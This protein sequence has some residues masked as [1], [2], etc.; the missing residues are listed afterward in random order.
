MLDDATQRATQNGA[1]LSRP[2]SRSR[3]SSICRSG[4]TSATSTSSA[5][6]TPNL[7]VTAASRRSS[8]AAS[9]RGAPAS[10]SATTSR[11]RCPTTRGPTTSRSAPSGPTRRNMLRVAYNGSWFNNLDA[12]LVWD[13][14]LR[15]DRL[16]ERAGQRPHVAVAVQ[17]RA[18]D[19]RR[20]L[21]QVRAQDA[22]HRL[23]LVRR[24]EQ[25]RAAAAVHDQFGAADD[26]AAAHHHR[27]RRARLLDQPEPG[28]PIRRPTGGS[29]RA[30]ADY[31]YNNHTPA[32]TITQYVAYDSSRVDVRRPA[33]R[34]STRTT[35]PRST[36]T[37]PGPAE[38]GRADGRL[39]AQRQR[40]RRAHLRQSPAR[41]CSAC[42]PT[43]SAR[44]GPPSTR[45]TSTGAAPG[46][47]STR[48]C[49]S[50]I[51]EQPEMRHYDLADRTRNQFTGR[52][53]SSRRIAWTFSVSGGVGTDDYPDTVFGLQHVD[54]PHRLARAP[55]STMPNGLGAGG[56]LQLRALRGPP[57]LAIGE[58]VG[59]AV[60][61]SDCATGRP[62]S[63][64]TVNYFSIYAT[65]PRIGRE[66][67]GAVLLRLQL[68]GGQLPL[69]DRPAGSPIPPPNQLPNVYNK[70][71]QL[72]IDVRHRLSNRAGGDV[73]VSLRAVPRLRLRVRPS[74]VNG[75]V[76][77]SSLVLGYVYR[78]YTANSGHDRSQILLVDAT[79]GSIHACGGSMQMTFS[80]KRCLIHDHA[81]ACRGVRD[82][83]PA[84]GAGCQ[85]GAG[86]LHRA[87]VPDL[88]RHRRQRQQ[89]ESAGRRRRRSCRP[90]TSSSG[91][92]IRPR[93]RPRP[94]RPRSRRCRPSTAACR[95]L[96]STRSSPTCRA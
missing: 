87:E 81:R 50:Q 71:Q 41:T 72:H 73:L 30:S 45:N 7:D 37:R 95:P 80:T 14:P 42:R 94:S 17:L 83:V 88:P 12:T 90:T 11:C 91:S 25:Q 6:P 51:G 59:R 32:T 54:V 22:G 8:T 63:T 57:A 27:G 96:I 76:Q 74:V 65:P 56:D 52:S 35:G 77:P 82:G 53:T 34:S 36:P 19:Q 9:C 3:R 13:S 24:V 33:A 1:G 5:T 89:G 29:A 20:R 26:R 84:A 55:T 86:G 61:R 92:P 16:V 62:T 64:E 2:T 93:P 39:H 66:H 67:R 78:P 40:L 21:H 4:A 23:L 18:D 28:R 58:L 75:I 60:Q 15:L 70:L 49:S 48:A 79:R 47:A 10:A 68:R 38:A 44:S 85:E 43:R 69:H 31:N 46:R